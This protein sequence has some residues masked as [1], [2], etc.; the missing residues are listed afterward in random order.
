[1]QEFSD[2]DDK[3]YDLPSPSSPTVMSSVIPIAPVSF[4]PAPTNNRTVHLHPVSAVVLPSSSLEQQ[5]GV[6]RGNDQTLPKG[7]RA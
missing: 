2:R 3:P 7:R 5:Q 4:V 1:M 6:V